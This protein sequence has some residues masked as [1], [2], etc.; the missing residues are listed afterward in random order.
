M[1]R[2]PGA[3]D[4]TGI[5]ISMKGP[6]FSITQSCFGEDDFDRLMGQSAKQIDRCL[7]LGVVVGSMA[8]VFI[9]ISSFSRDKSHPH[10]GYLV[11]EDTRRKIL[12]RIRY[13]VLR[14]I[15]SYLRVQLL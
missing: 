7:A 4:A 1:S 14:I 15:R 13:N 3:R 6:G 10:G 5:R 11:G 8:T 9:P 2:L 12:C